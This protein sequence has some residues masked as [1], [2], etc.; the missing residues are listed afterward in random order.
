[1]QMHVRSGEVFEEQGNL[2]GLSISYANQGLIYREWGQ[3][4]EALKMH[5]K[6]E[7][8]CRKAKFADGLIRS[9]GY[10]AL[11]LF[12]MKQYKKALKSFREQEKIAVKHKV[13]LDDIFADGK[14]KVENLLNNR[15][16]NK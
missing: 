16:A 3:H 6:E 12:E 9:L 1:M 8:L 14:I 10:Q 4:E 5:E 13:K 2:T 7:E 15:E 11:A